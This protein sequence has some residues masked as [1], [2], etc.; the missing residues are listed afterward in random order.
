MSGTHFK[1]LKTTK[2]EAFGRHIGFSAKYM[3]ATPNLMRKMD[4]PCQNY[5]KINVYLLDILVT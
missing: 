2:I 1:I 5:S 4:S 3:T